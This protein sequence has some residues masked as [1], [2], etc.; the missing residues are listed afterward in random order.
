MSIPARLAASLFFSLA[1]A[2]PAPAATGTSII[3]GSCLGGQVRVDIPTDPSSP[4]RGDDGCCKTA[5][6]AGQDRRKKS[7][8]DD[9]G[10]C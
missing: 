3:M 10:C 2:L 8:S 9:V 1:F 5:C 6:H 4:Q 7:D